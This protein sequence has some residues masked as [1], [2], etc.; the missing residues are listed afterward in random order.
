VNQIVRRTL[1]GSLDFAL[2]KMGVPGPREPHPVLFQ[3]A[4]GLTGG[5]GGFLGLAALAIELP[6]TTTLILRSIAGIAARHGERFDQPEARLA[7]V[8]VFAFGPNGKDGVSGEASY[9]ATRAI[10]ARTVS[11]ATQN[12][13]QRGAA[14]TS[15]PVIVDLISSIGSRLGVVVSERVAAGAIPVVGALGGAAINLVFMQHFQ[16]VARAHF[17][18]RKL[19]RIYG[20]QT[21]RERYHEYSRLRKNRSHTNL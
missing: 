20:S 19:E 9:L 16:R 10:L 5:V 18:V 8:E 6:V 1:A 21:I 4:S 7:C 3:A 15:A 2:N 14:T 13:L 11:E 17:A 12:L